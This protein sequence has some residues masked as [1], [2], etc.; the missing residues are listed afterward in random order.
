MEG[1]ILGFPFTF[2]C[3]ANMRID[4]QEQTRC[5][6]LSPESSPEK[7]AAGIDICIAKN[8]HKN[9]YDTQLENNQDRRCLMDRVLYIKSLH[10]DSIDIDDSDYL[11]AR[12]MEGREVLLPK[13]QREISHFISIVKGITLINAP[14]RTKDGKIIVSNS[15]IDEAM[16]LWKPLSESMAY[17]ISPQTYN[18]YK[19]IILPAYHIKNKGAAQKKG[20]TYDEIRK[21]YFKQTGSYPNMENIRKQYV[22]ALKTAALI[23]C[24]KDE[25]DRRQKIIVPLVFLD[26]DLE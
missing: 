10:V 3:S 11:K 24:N 18:F 1:Y 23:S 15:D 19:N 17:G 9:D 25:D 16:K 4:E 14:F 22:P 21:E 12:F 2:F 5:L 7:I 26:D 6:I 8:S 13:T 20:I